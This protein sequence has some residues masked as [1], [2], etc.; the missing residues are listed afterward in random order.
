[1]SVK[2]W[3]DPLSQPSRSVKYLIQRL[4]VEHEFIHSAVF[5]DT[6]T[7]E[8]KRDVNPLGKVPVVEHDGEKFYESAS[9]MKYLMDALKGDDE[10]YPRKDFKKRSKVDFWFDWNNTSG[11][12]SFSGALFNIALGPKLFNMP[13]VTAAKKKELMDS[14]HENMKFI[15]TEL[16]D[17]PY[18]TGDNFT[19]C[20]VQVYNEVIEVKTILELDLSEYESLTAWMETL[21][22]DSIIKDLDEQFLKGLAE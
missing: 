13:E 17:K 3:W 6:R 14:V 4:G 15:D 21:K 10:L 19:I 2:L 8:F 9:I 5:K 12:P 1:M 20:D 7:E 18:L 11:R 22:K 16:G